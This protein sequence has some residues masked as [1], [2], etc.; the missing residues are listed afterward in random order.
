MN[1]Y[2]LRIRYGEIKRNRVLHQFENAFNGNMLICG[3]KSGIFVHI[4]FVR[5]L[6]ERQSVVENK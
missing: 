1:L 3:R 2:F 6:K 5:K 4:K